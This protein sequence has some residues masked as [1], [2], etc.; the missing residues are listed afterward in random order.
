MPRRLGRGGG[1]DPF[2]RRRVH[3][4]TAE[5]ARRYFAQLEPAFLRLKDRCDDLLRLNQDAILVDTQF[6]MSEAY[7]VA[8]MILVGGA[9]RLTDSGLSITEWK[10]V[11]GVIPP[12]TVY[13]EA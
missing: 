13:I 8:A 10:P 5:Q 1:D 4:T 12:L 11:T 6:V 2:D 9:T 3:C 7:R